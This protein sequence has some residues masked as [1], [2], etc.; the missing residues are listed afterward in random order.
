[1]VVG[2]PEGPN[3][4]GH[5]PH[6]N[7]F[8]PCSPLNDRRKAA[9]ASSKSVAC[10]LFSCLSLAHLLIFFL[11]MSGNVHPNPCPISTCSVCAGNAIWWGRSVQCCT[12]S[13]WV[14]LKCSLLFFSRFSTLTLSVALRSLFSFQQVQYAQVFP[15]KPA[16]FC[17]LFAGIGNTKKSLTFL[18]LLSDSRSVL[19]TLSS[20]PSFLLLQSLAGAILSLF[21]IYQAKMG[22][23]TL[24]SP[25]QPLG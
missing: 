13:Y 14:Y 23:R 24:V 12:C 15:L 21:L 11:L 5:S 18:L 17:K 9:P 7:H 10:I 4:P 6:T 19:A 3:Y 22:P 8:L 16:P 25:R 20:P 1:M 2:L